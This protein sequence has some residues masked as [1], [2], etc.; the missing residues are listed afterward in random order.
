MK[1][2]NLAAQSRLLGRLVIAHLT[3]P[4]LATAFLAT[5]NATPRATHN[6]G[7]SFTVAG[8]ALLTSVYKGTVVVT[9]GLVT[10][11][12]AVG[13]ALLA[14]QPV[15]RTGT[16]LFDVLLAKVLGASCALTRSNAPS[17]V[18]LS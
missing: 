15:A 17:T 10:G 5:S 7:A 16:A 11:T 13:A 2:T 4:S 8:L 1:I 6:G 12:A 3:A 9:E 18:K 14:Q